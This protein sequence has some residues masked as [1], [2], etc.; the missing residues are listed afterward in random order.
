M[1]FMTDENHEIKSQDDASVDASAH[2]EH[3]LGDRPPVRI[4][5]GKPRRRTW[6][7]A[8]GDL[9][10]SMKGKSDVISLDGQGVLSLAVVDA[11][12]GPLAEIDSSHLSTAMSAR[13]TYLRQ[14]FI[15]ILMAAA[16]Q[17]ADD[18]VTE[19]LESLA[20]QITEHWNS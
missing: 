14:Q 8:D 5:P 12:Y 10:Q 4:N 7:D 16:D 3:F 15:D 9:W 2:V 19:A 18:N 20:K 17:A 13:E 11:T 6:V 1:T